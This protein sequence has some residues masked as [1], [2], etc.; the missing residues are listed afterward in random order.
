MRSPQLHKLLG[1]DQR[2]APAFFSAR[3]FFGVLREPVEGDEDP[4]FVPRADPRLF[5]IE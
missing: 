2:E 5:E 4:E 1:V 3:F